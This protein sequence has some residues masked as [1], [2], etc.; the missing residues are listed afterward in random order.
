MVF[1]KK[2]VQ[3]THLKAGKRN[4]KRK[5]EQTENKTKMADISPNISIITLNGDDLK[6]PIKR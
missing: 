6:T 1:S 3:V 2:T 4:T 5:M